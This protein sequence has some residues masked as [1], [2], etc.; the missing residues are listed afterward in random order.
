MKK[1]LSDICS[2]RKNINSYQCH[3]IMD[4]FFQ[5]SS[6]ALNNESENCSRMLALCLYLCHIYV[7]SRD[8][9]QARLSQYWDQGFYQEFLTCLAQQLLIFLNCIFVL[10]LGE[11]TNQSINPSLMISY[12]ASCKKTE[13][14]IYHL[15][16][17]IIGPLC[18]NM[19]QI[20]YTLENHFS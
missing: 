10:W 18:I 17:I 6:G 1:H 9:W 4:I 8:V 11:W 14:I 5:L 2:S 20:S 16:Q 7:K 15:V 3:I 13:Q 19:E 12:S